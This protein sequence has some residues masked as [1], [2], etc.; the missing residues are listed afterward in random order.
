[1]TPTRTRVFA[2]KYGKWSK[3]TWLTMSLDSI[4]V[5]GTS[6]K[7]QNAKKKRRGEKKENKSLE[8][9]TYHGK[10]NAKKIKNPFFCFPAHLSSIAAMD[11]A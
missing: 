4:I 8:D 7:V 1:M 9:L 3:G 5:L 2:S 11:C 10:E 6:S